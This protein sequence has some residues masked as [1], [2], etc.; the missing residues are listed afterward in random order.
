MIAAFITNLALAQQSALYRVLLAGQVAFYVAALVGTWTG[1]PLFRL[2][3]FLVVAN[4]AVLQAWLRFVRG[5]RIAVWT[6]SD[7]VISRSLNNG[8]G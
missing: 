1:L 7:R 2:P 8:I 5:D 6:P 3:G 4:L